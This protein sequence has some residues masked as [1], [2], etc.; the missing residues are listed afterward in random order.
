[1]GA[2]AVK[3]IGVVE[4]HSGNINGVN[5]FWTSEEALELIKQGTI[6][7]R[8]EYNNQTE[9]S[10]VDPKWFEQPHKAW[11]DAC[12]EKQKGVMRCIG[13]QLPALGWGRFQWCC[14]NLTIKA[15]SP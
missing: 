8:C 14:K 4:F 1:M 3:D 10:V 12:N 2:G 7:T 5:C 15:S 9:V 11:G 6:K 13:L